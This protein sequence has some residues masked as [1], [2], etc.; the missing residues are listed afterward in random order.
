VD[1]S[2]WG[3]NPCVRLREDGPSKH[4]SP[5]Q[6]MASPG[7]C[8]RPSRSKSVHLVVDCLSWQMQ[9]HKYYEI[10]PFWDEDYDFN[11]YAEAHRRIPWA[12]VAGTVEKYDKLSN[13]HR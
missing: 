4:V 9:D 3:W 10:T 8:F 13:V 11:P 12:K 5:E 2:S 1:V 6:E 7:I